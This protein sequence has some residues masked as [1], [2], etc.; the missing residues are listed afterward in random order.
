MTVDDSM[1]KVTDVDRDPTDTANTTPAGQLVYTLTGLP[2]QGELHLRTSDGNWAILGVGGRFTQE[3]IDAGRVSYKQT[4]NVPIG[5]NTP[6]KF[7]FTVCDSA[8][9]YA[10]N[11]GVP[12]ETSKI[13]R[14]SCRERV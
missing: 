7:T 4:M 13:G 14:A 5:P 11:D 6:D 10:M 3:D 1:L 9:G 8:F 2:Q 12:N